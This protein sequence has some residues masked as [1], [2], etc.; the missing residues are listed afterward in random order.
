[1]LGENSVPEKLREGDYGDAVQ[2]LLWKLDA[3]ESMVV[4]EV[5]ESTVVQNV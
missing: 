1:M 2:A 3:R 4:E 5:E